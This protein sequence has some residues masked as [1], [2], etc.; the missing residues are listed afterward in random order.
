[1]TSVFKLPYCRRTKIERRP[2][3]LNLLSPNIGNFRKITTPKCPT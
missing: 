1:V 2:T 3:I